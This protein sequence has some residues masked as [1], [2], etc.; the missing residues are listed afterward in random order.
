[1]LYCSQI[2]D[3][4]IDHAWW[5]RPED[6]TMDRPYFTVKYLKLKILTI[7]FFTIYQ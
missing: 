6:M 7:F 2:G 1:M 4:N 3:G 5:G